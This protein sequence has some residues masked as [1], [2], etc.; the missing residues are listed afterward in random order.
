MEPFRCNWRNVNEL[1]LVFH[2]KTGGGESGCMTP[3]DHAAWRAVWRSLGVVG[4]QVVDQ[5]LDRSERFRAA[6][7]QT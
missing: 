5:Q 7:V 3:F 6:A 4:D 1:R 2:L